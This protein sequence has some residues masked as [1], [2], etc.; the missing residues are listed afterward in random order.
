MSN[1][2]NR[3]VPWLPEVPWFPTVNEA[4]DQPDGL[5]AAG[6]DLTVPWLSLAY[7]RGIFP[8]FDE[9]PIL[10]WCPDP[11][12]VI[13]PDSLTVS[14][15]L[16]KALRR[17]DYE[18]RVN[19]RFM[20]VVDACSQP[21]DTDSEEPGTWITPSMKAAYLELYQ[22][23]LAHAIECYRDD[24]LIGGLYGV[25]IGRM[26]F[27]ESM[28]YRH[29]DASKIALAHLCRLLESHGYPLIDCQVDNPHLKRLGAMSMGRDR[30][31]AQCERLCELPGLDWSSLPSVLPAW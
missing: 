10:W 12:T 1:S 19:T 15:S 26:F 18:I 6:G 27:G 9:P 3:T 13:M 4:L 14:R 31:C 25:G 11:R 20:D 30:F 29:T 2:R 23:G 21:R 24:T 5:L 16:G 8:W 17:N 28:F 7:R 22:Q